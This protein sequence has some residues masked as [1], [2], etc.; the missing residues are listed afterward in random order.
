MR[1]YISWEKN[2]T[3]IKKVNCKLI[4][5]L[6]KTNS[7]ERKKKKKRDIVSKRMSIRRG[8]PCIA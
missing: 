2:D 8:M 6:E 5:R 1:K 4:Y 3:H 7:E